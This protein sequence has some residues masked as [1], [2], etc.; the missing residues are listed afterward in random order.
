M[1]INEKA[2]E[3]LVYVREFHTAQL[4]SPGGGYLNLDPP[5]KKFEYLTTTMEN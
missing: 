1:S 4:L 3:M 5:T 2:D